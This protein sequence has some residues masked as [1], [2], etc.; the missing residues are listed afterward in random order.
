MQYKQKPRPAKSVRRNEHDRH[1]LD[2]SEIEVPLC[3][4][5]KTIKA[6]KT[7]FILRVVIGYQG[8]EG[9]SLEPLIANCYKNNNV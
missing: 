7:V 1:K 3:E 9:G 4:I 6:N 8:T 2:I 5:F